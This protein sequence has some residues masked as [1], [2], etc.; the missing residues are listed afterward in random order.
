MGMGYV[1][2]MGAGMS[3]ALPVGVGAAGA[4]HRGEADMLKSR[5]RI[6]ALVLAIAG[7]L[8]AALGSMQGRRAPSECLSTPVAGQPGTHIVTCTTRR[9]P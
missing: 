4:G 2:L 7:A 3:P 6:I 5:L 9:R 8:G 1:F